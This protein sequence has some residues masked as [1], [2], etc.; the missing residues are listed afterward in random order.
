MQ[1]RQKKALA[2]FRR[3]RGFLDARGAELGGINATGVRRTIDEVVAGLE[4][5]KSLQD[6]LKFHRTKELERVRG[7]KE[8]LR[9]DWLRPISRI[10]SAFLKAT[11]EFKRL[12]MPAAWLET[13]GVL[14]WGR[15]MA[16][17]A[18]LHASVFIEAALP[19]DFVAQFRA[20]LD[21]LEAAMM[22]AENGRRTRKGAGTGL[23]EACRRGIK[24][25]RMI[26]AVLQGKLRDKP[27]LQTEWQST[28]NSVSRAV[29]DEEETTTETD[30]APADGV[31]QAA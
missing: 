13:A 26:D 1:K 17:A 7:L 29:P 31:S 18:E 24:A 6:P 8:Q 22:E 27:I 16:A 12:R 14:D 21:E 28:K 25:V 19:E 10:G 20:K 5:L 11:P 4:G 30:V 9:T 2:A 23:E 3:V 15:E